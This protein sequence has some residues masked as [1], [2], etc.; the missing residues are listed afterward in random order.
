MWQTSTPR[1]ATPVVMV[2]PDPHQTLFKFQKGRDSDNTSKIMAYCRQRNYIYFNPI[3][4]FVEQL[5][6]G[7]SFDRIYSGHITAHGNRIIAQELVNFLNGIDY[8]N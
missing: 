1:G 2:I 8:N 5:K 3:D 7:V 6:N 4:G